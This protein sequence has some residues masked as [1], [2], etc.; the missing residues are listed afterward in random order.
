MNDAHLGNDAQYKLRFMR[1]GTAF[2]KVFDSEQ[3]EKIWTA[4][5]AAPCMPLAH[6]VSIWTLHY[7]AM[8]YRVI[9]HW[10]SFQIKIW[11][12]RWAKQL[13]WFLLTQGRGLFEWYEQV[14][15][16]DLEGLFIYFL[17][18]VCIIMWLVQSFLICWWL[19]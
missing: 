11:I 5:S 15:S 8:F 14:I 6:C 13:V 3:A 2:H 1:L 9:Y 17:I 12:F 19:R 18:S 16:N 7:E 4:S 10:N